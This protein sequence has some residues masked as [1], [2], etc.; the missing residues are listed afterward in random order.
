MANMKVIS[1]ALLVALLFFADVEVAMGDDSLCCN[2][3]PKFG[4]CNTNHDEER[5]NQ[6]CLKG[7]SNQ[8]GGFCKHFSHGGQCHCYC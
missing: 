2:T 3:H 5:C 1:F 8:K 7:C 4:K 6:W